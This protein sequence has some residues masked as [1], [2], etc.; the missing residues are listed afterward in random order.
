M[1]SEEKNVTAVVRLNP[2]PQP[3]KKKKRNHAFSDL[4]TDWDSLLGAVADHGN[5]LARVEPYR[6]A[7]A[8]TLA[9]IKATKSLQVSHRATK[10]RSTQQ[11]KAM[12]I[13]AKDRAARLRGAIRAEMGTANEQL[14]QFGIRPLRPRVTRS[15]Q[16]ATETVPPPAPQP[17]AQTSKAGQEA[18]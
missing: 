15:Q 17:E 13:E 16:S 8:D 1:Q 18:K 4:L 9:Q 14:V 3:K 6:S 7:L 5:D 10:Q 2:D 12:L 11:L